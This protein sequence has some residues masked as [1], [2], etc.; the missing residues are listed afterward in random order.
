MRLLWV[1]C[2]AKAELSWERFRRD[3]QDIDQPA[4][5]KE[6]ADL[7]LGD[8][9]VAKVEPGSIPGLKKWRE[10][11]MTPM[12]DSSVEV[13]GVTGIPLSVQASAE[14]E[15]TSAATSSSSKS[16]SAPV[17]RDRAWVVPRSAV[18]KLHIS[19]LD[20]VAAASP[21]WLCCQSAKDKFLDAIYRGQGLMEGITAAKLLK[22]KV[23]ESC[24]SHLQD[25]TVKDVSKRLRA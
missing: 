14:P 19:T 22:R 13:D 25:A 17:D 11:V 5:R 16:A 24:L 20:S 18:A 8:A 12:K 1:K 3:V 9:V 4:V 7:L 10:I 2:P 15:K 21:T 6:V 23:C